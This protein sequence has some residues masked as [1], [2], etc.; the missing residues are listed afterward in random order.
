[1]TSISELTAKLH[2]KM[3]TNVPGAPERPAAPHSDADADCQRCA[4]W[5]WRQS[6]Q[7]QTWFVCECTSEARRAYLAAQA[8]P[9]YSRMGLREDELGMDWSLIKPGVSDGIAG[10]EAVK[11]KYMQGWGMVFL[12]GTWGQGK[13][14][15]GK[16]LT[17]TGLR[18][19]KRAAYA[20]VATVLDDIRL[21]FDSPEHKTTELLRR[22]DWWTSRDVLFLDEIDKVN[23]T[24]WA[25]ERIF[26]LLDQRYTRAIRE[27]ALTVIASNKSDQALDG[28]LK[29]RLQDRRLGP[30][31]YMHGP[32]ARKVMPEGMK[33]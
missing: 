33:F 27:E 12:W 22:M 1:M 16:I 10:A 29:S 5:G 3:A 32:D 7:Y 31:V 28:Y 4:G 24:T 2:A 25:E 26:Q 13:T 6:R 17:A 20:N 18:D 8:K 14:L 21:A 30:A 11:P 15:I 23:G 19:G 9:D